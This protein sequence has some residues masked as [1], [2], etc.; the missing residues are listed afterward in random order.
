M[1]DITYT[2]EI[3]RVDPENR[4][5]DIQYTSDQF[6]TILV[7]ARMPWDGETVEG[8]VR[9]FSPVRY[10]ME[11]TFSVSSVSAGTSGQIVESESGDRVLLWLSKVDLARAMRN[12]D[13]NG[14]SLWDVFKGHI[15]QADEVTQEDWSLTASF[16]ESDSLLLAVLTTIYGADAQ[17]HMDAL[18]DIQA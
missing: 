10:W 3:V 11:Q 18:F 9:S 8:I 13:H 15:A 6:G 14:Q 7:G 16:A 1:T 4:V 12:I 2:Y 5:M 17:S